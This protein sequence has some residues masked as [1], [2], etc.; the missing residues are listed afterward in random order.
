MIEKVCENCKFGA[1]SVNLCIK[2]MK[3]IPQANT[4]DYW[5]RFDLDKELH[6]NMTH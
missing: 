4:C 2:H 6:Y 1:T 3:E 5:K